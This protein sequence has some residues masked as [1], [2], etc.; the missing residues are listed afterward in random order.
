MTGDIISIRECERGCTIAAADGGERTPAPAFEGSTLCP[1]CIARIGWL[2]GEADDVAARARAAIIP[3]G[4]AAG[5]TEFISTSGAASAPLNIAAMEA[6]DLVVAT[7]ARWVTYWAS[8]TGVAPPGVLAGGLDG[9]RAVIGVAAGTDPGVVALAV[10]EW[11]WWLRAHRWRFHDSP[12]F[13]HFH[14]DL[15]DVLGRT[16]KQ[17]PRE[18]E[19]IIEQRP[20]YCPICEVQAVWMAWPGQVGDPQVK[21]KSCGW[22]YETDWEE[23]LEAIYSPEGSG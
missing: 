7:L 21:C 10:R 13:A 4:S 20:R 11:S 18:G 23:E 5:T 8:V 3:G 6:C 12:E 2:L 16:A 22:Q 19:R 1:R 9:N 14:D 15:R 17:F